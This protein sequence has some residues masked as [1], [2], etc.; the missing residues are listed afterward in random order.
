MLLL[1]EREAIF[2]D[3]G[4]GEHFSRDPL[5]LGL[6]LILCDTAIQSD[7]EI[8]SLPDVVQALIADFGERAVDRLTLRIKDAFLQRDVDVGFH[9]LIDYT[10]A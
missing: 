9:Q 1:F 7:F 3:H 10:L 4:I 6:R 2:F 5:N 8:F